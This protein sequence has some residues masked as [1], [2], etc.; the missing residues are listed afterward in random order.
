LLNLVGQGYCNR[1]F[2][3]NTIPT[4]TGKKTEL[5]SFLF[6]KEDFSFFLRF[7]LGYLIVDLI[8]AINVEFKSNET[9]DD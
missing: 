4:E 1:G 9:L 7:N 3:F 5:F 6:L 2:P 8:Q